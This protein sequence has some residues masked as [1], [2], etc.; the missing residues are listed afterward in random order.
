MR[1]MVEKETR[2]CTRCSI[3]KDIS[4]YYK[5][6]TRNGYRV[7]SH[8]KKCCNISATEWN[9]LHPQKS[10]EYIKRHRRKHGKQASIEYACKKYG[11]TVSEYL[12]KFRKQN[13]KC[14]IC[15]VPHLELKY[16]FSIDHCHTTN[17]FR[18]LLCG[19]CNIMLGMAKDSESILENAIHYLKKSEVHNISF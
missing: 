16:R 12:E 15:G 19:N 4:E 3:K 18:G 17:K 13:G 2:V 6:K 10:K 5:R 7:R 14:A 8:C 11:I 9:R 1:V